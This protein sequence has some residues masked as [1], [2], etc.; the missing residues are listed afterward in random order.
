MNTPE[1]DYDLLA[2]ALMTNPTCRQ[3]LMSAYKGKIDISDVNKTVRHE[4]RQHVVKTLSDLNIAMETKKQLQAEVNAAAFLHRQTIHDMVQGFFK[5]D[6]YDPSTLEQMLIAEIKKIAQNK[7]SDRIANIQETT[8]KKV[9]AAIKAAFKGISINL[10]GSDFLN[11]T[12]EPDSDWDND[13]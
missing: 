2:I 13:D 4:V 12:S 7:I 5:T 10:N 6:K 11:E 3:I 8:S 9:N 1:I